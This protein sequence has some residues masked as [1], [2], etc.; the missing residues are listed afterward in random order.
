MRAELSDGAAYAGQQLFRA[1]I[2]GAAFKLTTTVTTGVLANTTQVA[3]AGIT[4]FATRFASTFDEYRIVGAD[5]EIQPITATSGVLR[6]WFD[7]KSTSAPTANE[8][9]ERT[10]QS[11]SLSNAAMPRPHVMRWRARDL[12]DL[13]YKAIGTDATPVSFKVYTDAASWGAPAVATDVVVVRYNLYF[14][15]RGLKST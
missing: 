8:A 3:Q 12:L 10:A 2:P 13:E 7:E 6:C 15:F 11:V 14:E 4:G 9:N 1:T 5:V